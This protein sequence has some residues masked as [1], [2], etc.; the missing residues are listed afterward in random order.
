[1]TFYFKPSYV[2]E[3]NASTTFGYEAKKGGVS[4]FKYD[5]EH[6]KVNDAAMYDDSL[7]TDVYVRMTT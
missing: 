2:G 4:M 5:V 1:M 6:K 3:N 7:K